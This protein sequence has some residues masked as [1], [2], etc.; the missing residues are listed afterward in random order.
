[1]LTCKSCGKHIDFELTKDE[2]QEIQEELKAV[3][4]LCI[5]CHEVMESRA[6]EKQ[7]DAGD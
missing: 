7:G 1:M 2:E 3:V 6:E 5:E 4:L